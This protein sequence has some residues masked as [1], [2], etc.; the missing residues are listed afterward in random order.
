M[1]NLDP[2]LVSPRTVALP[3]GTISYI[4]DGDGPTL[5]FVHAGMWSVIFSDVISRLRHDFRCITFDFPG[6]GLSPDPVDEPPPDRRLTWFSQTVESLVEHLDLTDVTLV[7]HDLGGSAA[8]AAAVRRP[9]RYRAFVLANTFIWE[10]DTRALRSMLRVVGSGPMTALG[11]ATNLVPRLTSGKGGVG[12]HYDDAD[13]RRFLAPFDDRQ[14]R[15]RFHWA[16][17][18]AVVDRGLV[19]DL[20]RIPAVVGDRPVLSIFGEKNDPFGF[21]PRIESMF[22]DHQSLVIDSGNHFPMCDD[23]ELFATTVRQWYRSRVGAAQS[24]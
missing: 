19:D 15:R 21:Q 12:L 1:N 2:F 11:V 23:P 9:E 17:R 13:R 4:D 22:P 8:L 14:R 7:A 24:G 20:A 10:A 6:Y 16:M 3:S 18:S 5:L